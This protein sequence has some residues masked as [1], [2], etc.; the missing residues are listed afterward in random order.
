MHQ[1][2]IWLMIARVA[3]GVRMETDL[4]IDG[5]EKLDQM[6]H[7]VTYAHAGTRSLGLEL[8]WL[9][10]SSDRSLPISSSRVAGCLFSLWRRSAAI[11]SSKRTRGSVRACR[12]VLRS[13]RRTKDPCLGFSETVK[14]A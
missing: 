6:I 8:C 13:R 5:I 1:A 2:E 4:R 10:G 3:N 7:S 14:L 12:A 9:P 11:A